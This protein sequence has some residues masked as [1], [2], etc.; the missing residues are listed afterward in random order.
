MKGVRAKGNEKKRQLLEL[1]VY[2]ILSTASG[3][4]MQYS[5]LMFLVNNFSQWNFA[6]T[7]VRNLMRKHINAGFLILDKRTV[8]GDKSYTWTLAADVSSDEFYLHGNI[9]KET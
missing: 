3:N 6:H 7:S 2:E 8:N 5:D 4:S 1:A 9:L